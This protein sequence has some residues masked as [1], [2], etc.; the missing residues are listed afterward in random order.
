MEVNL[1][2]KLQNKLE[3]DYKDPEMR[4]SKVLFLPAKK[5]LFRHLD[6]EF[7]RFKGLLS[8]F[9]RILSYRKDTTYFLLVLSN[10]QRYL[11]NFNNQTRIPRLGS[12]T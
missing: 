9:R 2:P 8:N 12:Q 3:L 6:F 7:S 4:K 10:W 11:C 5:E 1:E